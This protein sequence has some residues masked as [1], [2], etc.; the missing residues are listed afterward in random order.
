MTVSVTSPTSQPL[1]K[2]PIPRGK[3]CPCYCVVSAASTTERRKS[4]GGREGSRPSGLETRISLL[5]A[6]A[7]QS[8]SRSQRLLIDLATETAKYLF[9]KR[10]ESRNLEEF[11]MAVPDL[12]TVKF[13]VLRRMYEYEIREVEPYF[14]AEMT[15]PGRN[16]FDFGGASQAFNVLAAYLF[17][18]N[19]GNE[20]MEMTTPVYI[21]KT[22]SD[23]E[24]LNM[25]TPVIMKQSGDLDKWQMSFVMPSKYGA[26]LPLPKDPS[27][28][29]KEV[30][31]KVI[32]VGAFSGFVTDEEVKHRESKLRD[33]LRSNTEFQVKNNA[34]VEVAQY[35][36]PFTLPFTRRNEI[37][38]EVE[39]KNN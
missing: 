21:R 27:V 26:K 34:L 13:K 15:M 8:F 31:R 35:N 1:C 9:P 25:T 18:K 39:S 11:L 10:F 7:T 12:E 3:K 16:G 38:L 6:V 30:P 23:G 37:A 32:A 33:A 22:R 20:S 2:P 29:I 28:K 4:G 5:T 36:P 17:G 19:S 24:R 14:V